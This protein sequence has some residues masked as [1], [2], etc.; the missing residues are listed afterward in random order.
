MKQ[1]NKKT[2]FLACYQVHQVLV[3]LGNVLAGKGV[4]QAGEEKD[5]AGHD[6]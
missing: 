6:F 5:R 3:L 4:I 1:K 2:D